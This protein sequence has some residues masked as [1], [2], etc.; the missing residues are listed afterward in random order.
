MP[1]LDHT[2]N[3]VPTTIVSGANNPTSLSIVIGDATGWP[4]G[5]ANGKFWVTIARDQ[6]SE[7]RVLIQSRSGTTLTISGT[8]DRGRDGTVAGNHSPGVS[9]EHTTAGEEF[10]ELNEHLFNI[11]L[12]QHTQYMKADGT[13]HDLTARH[14]LGTS[15]PASVAPGSI[16]IGDTPALGSSNNAARADHRHGAPAFAAPVSIGTANGAGAAVTLPRS[17]HVHD[18]GNGAI[19]GI[20]LFSS[21]LLRGVVQDADPGAVGANVLWLQGSTRTLFVRNAANSGWEEWAFNLD[22]PWSTYDPGT[23][24][25]SVTLGAGGTKWGRYKKYGT[26]LV[27]VAG[28]SLG[29]GGDVTALI[30]IPLP[31]GIATTG[32]PYLSGARAR[33]GGTFWAGVG[34]INEPINANAFNYATA[35]QTGWNVNLPVGAG[36]NNGDNFMCFY[37]YECP[38]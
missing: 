5:G 30:E 17:D 18:I 12:D 19:D 15:V 29:V 13:R 28:F 35:G 7:E 24:D 21:T 2:G 32:V 4:T 37:L 14:L 33:I 25:S 31:T 27:G 3:A 36:W 11:A 26:M 20:G 9:I 22:A 10:D 6:S 38:A 1:Q 16:A 8:G 34:E 23:F